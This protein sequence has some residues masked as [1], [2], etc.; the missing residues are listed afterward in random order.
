VPDLALVLKLDECA[1]RVLE[2]DAVV[3]RVELVNRDLVQPQPAQAP[4][5]SL[6]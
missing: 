5:A 2:R 6:A 1:Q 4:L 3:R